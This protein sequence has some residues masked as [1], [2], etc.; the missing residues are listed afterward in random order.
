MVVGCPTRSVAVAVVQTT[1]FFKIAGNA[2]FSLAAE[3]LFDTRPVDAPP[4]FF[5]HD[6]FFGVRLAVNDTASTEVL[7]GGL[8][9]VLDGSTFAKAGVSQPL[10]GSLEGV[11]GRQRL[12]WPARK[13]GERVLERRLRAWANRVLLLRSL[14]SSA[15]SPRRGTSR[16]PRRRSSRGTSWPVRSDTC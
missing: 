11:T 7:A 9:D 3:F 8:V 5:N 1:R 15:Q 16:T 2:N 12:P 6:G 14:T 10:P 13:A 4:T